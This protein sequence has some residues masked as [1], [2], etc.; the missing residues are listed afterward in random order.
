MPDLQ[1]KASLLSIVGANWKNVIT[2]HG[3]VYPRLHFPWSFVYI[4]NDRI[5]IKAD[6]FQLFPFMTRRVVKKAEKVIALYQSDNA[7]RL[8]DR[9]LQPAFPFIYFQRGSRK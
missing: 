3:L 4:L 6:V 9:W 5:Y 8:N 2:A 7:A 1:L